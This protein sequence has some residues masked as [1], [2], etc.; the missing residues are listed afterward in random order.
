MGLTHYEVLGVDPA[1]D[2]ATIR[3]AYRKLARQTHPDL[4]G[5]HDEFVA[6][7]AAWAVLSDP[8]ARARY[9]EDVRAPDDAGWGEDVGLGAS[10]PRR[11]SSRATAPPARPSQQAGDAWPSERRVL[12]SIADEVGRL[13]Y[14]DA[15]PSSWA[16]TL[17]ATALLG[18]AITFDVSL[19]QAVHAMDVAT[20][21]PGA[22]V[23]SARGSSVY[24]LLYVALLLA[25][26]RRRVNAATAQKEHRRAAAFLLWGCVAA[27]PVLVLGMATSAA[28]GRT[29]AAPALPTALALAATVAVAL[30]A[31]RKARGNRRRHSAVSAMYQR[32]RLAE[33]WDAF[34]G[35][36]EAFPGAARV[37]HGVRDRHSRPTWSL[38]RI[39]DGEVLASA[40]T[41]A[42]EAWA[43]TLRLAGVDVT[44]T[45]TRRASG[46]RV[47]DR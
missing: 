25:S 43:A 12:P 9:D 6:V 47:D 35:A 34:L 7:S 20:V 3:A 10:A 27:F 22:V 32:R 15:K 8:D 42:P 4:G 16:Q 31:E 44:S 46:E 39:S 38:V 40:P 11:P 37:E 33:A 21:A 28:T 13:P 45:G 23:P 29:A 5:D 18:V 14:D 30:L 17:V 41:G 19:T 26:G 1:A 36:Q 2:D 24:A